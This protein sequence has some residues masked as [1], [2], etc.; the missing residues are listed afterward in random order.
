MTTT[1]PSLYVGTYAKYNNGSIAGKWLD[2]SEYDTAEDFLKACHK[3]HKDENDPEFM[4]QDF[5][6]FPREYY[7][8]SM[9]L[10]DL[11]Q[12][13]DFAQLTEDERERV[14]AFTEATGYTLKDY[15]VEQIEDSIEFIADNSSLMSVAEQLGYDHYEN[16]LLE[17]PEH[18]THYFDFEQYGRDVLMDCSE[19]DGYVFNLNRI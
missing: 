18:V 10:E 5:E 7:S 16:G 12:L 17:M 8:E 14:E 11:Q 1:Q 15:T 6:G 3:L 19:H 4:F 9:G 2:L 13:I